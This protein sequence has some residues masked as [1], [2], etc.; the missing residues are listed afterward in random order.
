MSAKDLEEIYKAH[1]TLRAAKG[2][3]PLYVDAKLN[4]AAEAHAQWMAKNR[5]MSHYQG[6]FW[7]RGISTRISEQGYKYSSIGENISAGQTTPEQAMHVW[8]YSPRHYSNIMG[9]FK[10]IGI[11]RAGNYWCVCFGKPN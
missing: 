5:K 9:N 3:S 2:L 10:H 1:N 7:S 4:S 8:R 11:A 6:F